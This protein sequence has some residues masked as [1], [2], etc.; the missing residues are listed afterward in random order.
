M[1]RIV[2]T[3]LIGCL[4]T[5]P[6]A[7]CEPIDVERIVARNLGAVV[8]IKGTRKGN[9]ASVQGSGCVIHPDGYVLAT[10][11]QASDVN[12]LVAKFADGTTIPLELVEVRP[13]IEYALLKAAKPLPHFVP[14]GDATL[15]QGGAP[16]VSIASPINLE[17]TTVTGAVANPN[18]T[19][20]GYPVLLVSLTATHGSSGG[21]VFDRNGQLIGLISGGLSEVNFTIV[22]KI[23]NAYPMLRERGLLEN[24]APQQA[25]EDMLVPVAGITEAELRAIEAYNR[26]V[27]ATGLTE[28]SEAYGLAFTLLPKFYEAC[29]N[30]AVAEARSGAIER[31]VATYRKAEALRPGA[32][33]VKRNLGR[34]FLADKSYNDAVAVFEA[35]LKLAPGEAQSHNDLGEAYR[36]AGDQGAAIRHFKASLEIDGNA[37]RT[38]F[39]LALA[40]GNSG[41]PQ[42]AIPHFEAYLALSPDAADA[43][44][45]KGYIE[46]LQGS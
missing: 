27:R 26:G 11:H 12:N 16:L 14:V 43:V 9:G 31:A 15:L 44:Q 8:L 45:V 46:K 18:K 30:L 39:N 10:A 33:E 7:L 13:A 32:V 36:R 21:P 3:I 28:K 40:Y 17:F 6:L 37:P 42:E 22:N 29:F 4:L 20:D 5:M 34:L 19:Y 1:Y 2:P 24:A 35:A 25:E 23:N 38:H 41:Q